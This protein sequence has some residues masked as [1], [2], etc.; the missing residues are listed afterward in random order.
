MVFLKDPFLF[1]YFS[2]FILLFSAKLS[3]SSSSQKLYADDTRLYI[4]YR[5]STSHTSL[6]LNILFLLSINWMS[7]NFLPLNLLIKEF[8]VNGLPN[9]KIEIF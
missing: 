5:L 8:L 1:L 7:F 2:F 9:K 4:S 6:N 3:D